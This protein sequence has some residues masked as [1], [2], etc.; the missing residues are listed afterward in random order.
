LQHSS[1]LE[2]RYCTVSTLM[3]TPSSRPMIR[4]SASNL[5]FLLA[6]ALTINAG[7]GNSVNVTNVTQSASEASDTCSTPV[8]QECLAYAAALL[9]DTFL[10]FPMGVALRARMNFITEYFLCLRFCYKTA[11]RSKTSMMGSLSLL[12]TYAWLVGM[13]TYCAQVV[14]LDYFCVPPVAS[15]GL[16]TCLG[17]ILQVLNAALPKHVVAP[18]PHMY[19][20]DFAIGDPVIYMGFIENNL[21]LAARSSKGRVLGPLPEFRFSEHSPPLMG[22]KVEVLFSALDEVVLIGSNDI[23]LDTGGDVQYSMLDFAKI[24]AEANYMIH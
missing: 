19:D 23:A 1:A 20:E 12:M 13:A 15:V 18:G 16:G 9:I 17:I 7:A 24:K 10:I 21:G 11:Q 14:P 6:M 8:I 2:I 22:G 4:I 3:I 5:I